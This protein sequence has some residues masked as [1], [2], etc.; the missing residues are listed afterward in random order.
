M[1]YS[2]RIGQN[3]ISRSAQTKQKLY[4]RMLSTDCAWLFSWRYYSINGT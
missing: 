2:R 4:T 1:D 3:G